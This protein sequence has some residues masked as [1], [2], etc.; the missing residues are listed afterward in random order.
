MKRFPIL[1]LT[2]AVFAIASCGNKA[3]QD[4][5]FNDSLG[6]TERAVGDSTLYGLACEGCTD[7]VLVFLSF[8]GG[9]PVTYDI[10]NA[11]KHKRI[12][13]QLETGDWVG[14]VLNP[15]DKKKADMV[16]DLDQLK[17]TWVYKAM[18]K[19]RNKENDANVIMTSEEKAEQDSLLKAA[20]TPREQGFSLKRSYVAEPV[21]VG[22]QN[23]NEEDSPVIY[24]ELKMYNE[25]HV[26][27]GKLL[28][29]ANKM[30]PQENKK[31]M[32]GKIATDTV[33]FV[34]MIKDSLQL[35]FKDGIRS[36]YRKQ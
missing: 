35:R 2:M 13:G 18:P 22:W 27:N 14:V 31:K 16:I 20:M 19:M 32:S 28:L 15:I 11:T 3:E 12:I 5:K 8:D 33:E 23:G 29:T 36:Y 24:P 34:F 26:Y 30:S 21:G 9:D 4:T 6:T 17:G 7:S 1:L 25:W 10:I